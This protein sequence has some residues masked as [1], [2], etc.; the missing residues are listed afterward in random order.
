[1]K[2]KIIVGNPRTYI[3]QEKA[4]M[5]ADVKLND[6]VYSMYFETDAEYGKYFSPEVSDAYLICLLLYAMER[7]YDIYFEGALSEVLYYQVVE[8][9]IPAL[10]KNIKEYS[11]IDVQCE[12]LV[13]IHFHPEFVAT[14]VSCGV[15]SFYTI[16][17]NLT[18]SEESNLNVNALTF[19]N[20][21]ASGSNGGKEARCLFQKRASEAKLVAQKMNCKFVAVDSN[22]NEFLNQDHEQ[23]H[24]FRTLSIPLAMQKFF[25]TY[26]FSSGFEYKKFDFKFFD[27]AFYDILTMPLLSTSNIRFVPVGGETTR[28]GKIEFISQYE[29]VKQHLNVCVAEA[30]NCSKCSKCKRT[31]LNLYVVGKLEDFKSVFDL[32]Y[33]YKNKRSFIRW[34]LCRKNETDIGEIVQALKK[35]KEIRPSDHV[36]SFFLKRYLN[37]RRVASKLKKIIK[38]GKTNF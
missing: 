32:D 30:N 17:K 33:F 24:V 28:L 27:P 26:Y 37:L 3:E 29:V 8:Y 5:S 18:H 13:N 23:T 16:L 12:K 2:N 38:N 35:Q 11:R 10:S 36:V 15:D 34:A 1:M 25:K 22:M 9:L 21:G 20:A 31:I 19:F 6:D 14:G 7:N 4:F